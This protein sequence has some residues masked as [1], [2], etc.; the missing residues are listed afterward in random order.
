AALID[1]LAAVSGLKL[2]S[3]ALQAA[4]DRTRGQVD[5]LIAGNS[6]HVTMVAK[7]EEVIDSSEGNALGLE[8]MPSADELAAELERFLRGEEH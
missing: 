4:G 8:E 2:D 5:E 6:E 1:G 7:L 3:T